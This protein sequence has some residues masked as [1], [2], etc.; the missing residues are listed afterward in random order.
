[1]HK[2]IIGGQGALSSRT[3]VLSVAPVFGYSTAQAA[4]VVVKAS[5]APILRH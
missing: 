2:L 3:N 4:L 1:M 5:M